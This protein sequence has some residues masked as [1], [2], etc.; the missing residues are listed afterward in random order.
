MCD[1]CDSI[2]IGKTQNDLNKIIEQHFQYVA[3]KVQYNKH[4]EYFTAHF[5]Q[6]FTKTQIHNI[7]AQLRLL[8]K[9]YRKSYWFNENLGW[10]VMNI[11]HDG[12]V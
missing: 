2:Y 12:Q 9:F 5:A 10:A 3:K 8:R 4:L 6:H 11:V 1:I 7:V